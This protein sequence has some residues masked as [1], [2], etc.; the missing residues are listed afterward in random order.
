VL[1]AFTAA[2][3]IPAVA[4]RDAAQISQQ[5]KANQARAEQRAKEEAKVGKAVTADHPPARSWPTCSNDTLG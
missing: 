5:E 2:V 3:S 4:G 1:I